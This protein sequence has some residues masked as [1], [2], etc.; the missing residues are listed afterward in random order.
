MAERYMYEFTVSQCKWLK[1]ELIPKAP[2]NITYNIEKVYTLIELENYI[3]T[4]IIIFTGNVSTF[5]TF[6]LKVEHPRQQW[7]TLD[8]LMA[9]KVMAGGECYR[10]FIRPLPNTFFDVLRHMAEW[11][12]LTLY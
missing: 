10:E 8:S 1:E 9:Q 7:G 2:F 3:T 6:T 4:A 11:K 12:P 5:A